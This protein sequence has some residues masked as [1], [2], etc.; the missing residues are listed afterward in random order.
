MNNPRDISAYYTEEELAGKNEEEQVE[1]LND[2]WEN[3]CISY[4]FEPGSTVKPITVACGLDTGTLNGSETYVCDGKEDFNG[5]PVNCVSRVGHGTETIEKSLMDSCNDALMQMSYS[6]G[7][8]NFMNYQ[9]IFGF[10]QKTGIDLPGEEQ[11]ILYEKMTPID[12]ATNSFGQNYNCTM[13]Q[14]AAA[15]SSLINGGQYY[16]P[17]V[18]KKILDPEGNTLETIKPVLLKETTS[19]ETSEMIK[20]YLYKTVSEGTGSEAKVNGY[21]MGGKTGTA[22]KHPRAEKKYL[23][24]FIGY[25]PQENPELVIYLIIDEPNFKEQAHSNYAQAVVK[26]ILEELLP[27]MNLYPDEEMTPVPEEEQTPEGSQEPEGQ[28]PEEGQEP[29]GQAPEGSQEPEG[30]TPEEG[31]EPFEDEIPV[32]PF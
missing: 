24:S 20:E 12:L 19:K 1:M 27:Y 14:V 26:E 30:Q 7:A 4:T 23:V 3:F 16:Q 18:V 28:A 11:G 9:E 29:E 25:L 22:Q 5:T 2:L 21:S 13:I 32:D 31:D 8:E 6:I 10:G 17:H 15:F